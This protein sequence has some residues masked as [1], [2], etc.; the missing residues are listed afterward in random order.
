MKRLIVL[1]IL[2]FTIPIHAQSIQSTFSE[3]QELHF[4]ASY[5]LDATFSQMLP[6]EYPYRLLASAFM[7]F[8]LGVLKELSDTKFSTNDLVSNSCGIAT[9]TLIS[10]TLD[11]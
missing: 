7:T 8:N 3:K 4:L 1:L 2:L 11:F 6:K 10:Y 9:Y 5:A